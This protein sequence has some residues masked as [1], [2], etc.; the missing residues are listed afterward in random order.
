V[1]W[2]DEE[3]ARSELVDAE[4]DRVRFEIAPPAQP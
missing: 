3:P 1:F 4:R 2:L